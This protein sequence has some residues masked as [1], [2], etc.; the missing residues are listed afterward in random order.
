[1]S[2]S[3]LRTLCVATFMVLVSL[4]SWGITVNPD[5]NWDHKLGG[6]DAVAGGTYF[7]LGP[8]GIRAKPD[9]L[10][11]EVK[12]VFANSPATGKIMVGD[13]IVG[14]NGKDFT[15]PFKFGYSLEIAKDGAGPLKNIGLAVEEAEGGT[16]ILT[17]KV[18]R[19][20]SMTDV[21]VSIR[22]LGKFSNTYPFNCYK[23]DQLFTEICEHLAKTQG[24]EWGGGA[25]VL[26][27]IA[28][29]T[30]LGSGNPKYAETI[31][32]V[33]RNVAKG[34]NPTEPGGLN[35]WSL[36]YSG[37]FL[38]EY[39]LATRDEE[40]LEGLRK[41]DEG[42]VFAQLDDGKFQH[43][44]NWGGYD[45][46]GVMEALAVAA[47]SMV[48]KCGV[49]IAADKME[50]TRNRIFK[51]TSSDGS[52]GYGGP[53]PPGPSDTARTGA[54]V[55]AIEYSRRTA[56][57]DKYVLKGAKWLG[58]SWMWFHDCH[59][60]EGVGMQWG[61]LG[62]VR[63]PESLRKILDSQIWYFNLWRSY[64][65]GQFI[66]QPNSS[67]ID[68]FSFSRLWPTATMG[69]ILS[70]KEKSLHVTGM[71]LRV[72]GLKHSMLSAGTEPLY[73]MLCEGR[74]GDAFAAISNFNKQQEAANALK[75]PSE[76]SAQSQVKA[77]MGMTGSSS[78]K[79]KSLVASDTTVLGLLKQHITE[80]TLSKL[81]GL[82]TLRDGGDMLKFKQ[83]LE[84]AKIRFLGV[85]EFKNA[86][87]TLERDLSSESARKILA[88]GERWSVLETQAKKFPSADA[89][90]ALDSFAKE[91]AQNVYGKKAIELAEAIKFKLDGQDP[92]EYERRLKEAS[93]KASK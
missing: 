22:K 28:G 38:G 88:A 46:L 83:H 30:L 57:D 12:H 56:D 31:K 53:L 75:K 7:N 23:S 90:R 62:A 45:E 63:S 5:F 41:V 92:K 77:M 4:D 2:S 74:Y 85:P 79:G 34:I 78:P 81:V 48:E 66:V 26:E 86:L 21:P 64:E 93:K 3:G 18:K 52:M 14:V 32:K 72:N 69:L 87:P 55:L 91:N 16:G 80:A 73:N 13:R 51:N 25:G 40:V 43:Q 82:K 9:G 76:N 11:L 6:D 10:Q 50:L 37:I 71:R 61:A 58:D 59:G 29:L 65:P 17:L 47:W 54:A 19:G 24:R 1:M 89:L 15:I 84:E 36:T 27:C 68:M 44:K 20:S 70:L 67:G 33:A 35:N 42:L 8:T 49:P 60:S 39:Y